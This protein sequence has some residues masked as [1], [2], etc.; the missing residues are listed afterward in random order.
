ML[1]Y[2]WLSSHR[3][4]LDPFQWNSLCL[5][6]AKAHV[7]SQARSRHSYHS[8]FAELLTIFCTAVCRTAVFA[9]GY[10]VRLVGSRLD[11]AL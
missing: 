8:C 6:S 3:K 2:A 10:L 9:P 11:Q 7:K 1:G 4:S 5:A